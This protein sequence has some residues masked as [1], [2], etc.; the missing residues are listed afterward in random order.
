[1][2]VLRIIARLNVGG[3]ARHVVW[4]TQALQGDGVESKL[5]AG[6]VPDGEE[7][8]SYFAA[9]H[10]VEPIYIREM[11]R[12]LSPRD[13]VS[14]LKV[15]R[16]IFRERPDVIHTHTAKAGTVGRAAAFVYK[17]LTPGTIVGRPR[18][19]KVIHTFHGHVFH[20]YYGRLKTQIF[21]LI[22]KM[23]ARLASD[24]IV[25]ITPQ[26]LKEIHS[27]V[28]VGRSEQFEIIPL[29][30]DLAKLQ[31][32]GS[33]RIEFRNEFAIPEATLLIGFVGRL[34]EIKNL[35]MLLESA[36]QYF[37]TEDAPD[38][39][40][41]IIGDGHMRQELERLAVS[42]GDRVVFAGNRDDLRRVYAG[43]DIIGLTSLN[44]GTPLSLIEAMAST[45]PVIATRV[46]GVVDLLGAPEVEEAGFTVHERGVG[47]RS[48]DAPSFANGLIY[49]AKNERLRFDL[50]RRGHQYAIDNYGKERLIADIRSLYDRLLEQ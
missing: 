42:L 43:L 26:Q 30:I 50:G 13:A 47:V 16:T 34:T 27:D 35:P 9:E 22:E 3:P 12:E 38:A 31:A 29:G 33:E 7:D 6:T 32:G 23:L 20:S 19:V 28:G 25:V 11:S 49:L 46:G 44:E 40:F 45:R 17:W 41:I 5:I 39:K 2:K 1:V 24:K 15:L 18:R 14:F 4:L 8:M 37:E 48:E 10:G 36:K 21:V